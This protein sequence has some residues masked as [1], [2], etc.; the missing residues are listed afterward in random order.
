M[1]TQNSDEDW[2]FSL[3]DTD[4]LKQISNIN[5]LMSGLISRSF[6][7]LF[8]KSPP[9]FHRS[10]RLAQKSWIAVA[11]N[12]ID[13]LNNLIRP[14][15]PQYLAWKRIKSKRIEKS[16]WKPRRLVS[17]LWET[18]LSIGSTDRRVTT[19][20]MI[21]FTL[22]VTLCVQHGMKCPIISLAFR[23]NKSGNPSENCVSVLFLQSSSVWP[24]MGAVTDSRTTSAMKDCQIELG[25]T[26]LIFQFNFLLVTIF[27]WIKV[28]NFVNTICKKNATSGQIPRFWTQFRV[29]LSVR[30]P[31]PL[32]F[33]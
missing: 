24:K 30:L 32:G 20:R 1:H 16:V 21:S 11:V 14:N 9:S 4:K 23:N 7:V 13:A 6:M 18:S 3:S 8:L 33:A 27:Y 29:Q 5:F 15:G 22:C 25:W 31:F 26:F 2:N 19:C 17:L 10:S 28:V 12:F